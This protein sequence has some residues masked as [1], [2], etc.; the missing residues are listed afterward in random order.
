MVRTVFDVALLTAH[1]LT[2]S[3]G[4]RVSAEWTDAPEPGEVVVRL[5]WSDS[6]PV[7]VHGFADAWT[8]NAVCVDV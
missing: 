8:T 3:L 6:G 7:E 2:N 5:V 4:G 1:R